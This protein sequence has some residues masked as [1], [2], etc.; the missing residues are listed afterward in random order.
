M[1]ALPMPA[2]AWLRTERRILQA[3]RKQVAEESVEQGAA[4]KRNE[5]EAMRARSRAC[6]CKE[7]AEK[8]AALSMLERAMGVVNSFLH[9]SSESPCVQLPGCYCLQCRT[10]E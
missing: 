10:R 3:A 9:M 2:E 4:M 7:C 1:A 6:D 8:T 5:A